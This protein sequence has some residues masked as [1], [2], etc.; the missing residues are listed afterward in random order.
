MLRSFSRPSSINIL[1]Y[2]SFFLDTG[3]FATSFT[4]EKTASR[5]ERG[6]L[7]LPR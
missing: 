6:L 2:N 1:G 5:G 4:L 3:A 7:Y